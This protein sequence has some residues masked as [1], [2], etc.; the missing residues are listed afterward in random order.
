MQLREGSVIGVIGFLALSGL[1]F[2]FLLFA[3]SGHSP[4]SAANNSA[5]PPHPGSSPFALTASASAPAAAPPTRQ[6]LPPPVIPAGWNIYQAQNA[7]LLY[8]CPPDWK[9]ASDANGKTIYTLH[10]GGF[11]SWQTDWTWPAQ[12]DELMS[13][14]EQQIG[15][16]GTFTGMS[17]NR[18]GK[19]PIGDG[20]HDGYIVEG[21]LKGQSESIWLSYAVVRSAQDKA[22]V[23]YYFRDH[24]QAN[25]GDPQTFAKVVVSERDGDIA[26]DKK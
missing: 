4:S 8:A 23:F 6:P 18:L 14:V 1:V 13:R 20:I 12:S 3:A 17:F 11:W 19:R 2:I 15:E 16:A 10:A 7:A 26:A 9:I 25:G 24:G 21:E 22:L 5:T